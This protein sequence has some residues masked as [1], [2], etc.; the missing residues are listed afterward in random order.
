MAEETAAEIYLREEMELAK[1]FVGQADFAASPVIISAMPGG[2]KK[3]R[4]YHHVVLA[5]AEAQIK[6]NGRLRDLES[7]MVTRDDCAK[8]HAT[9]TTT[10]TAV[11]VGP[12]GKILGPMA[13]FFKGMPAIVVGLVTLG[14]LGTIFICAW[15]STTLLKLI[16]I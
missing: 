3:M 15:R 8:M 10:N 4:A 9:D 2:E 11:F 13:A 12:A 16:G 7:T 5:G 1:D 6:M 14:W